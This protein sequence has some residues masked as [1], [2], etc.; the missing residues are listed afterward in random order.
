[1]FF[2]DFG[3]QYSAFEFYKWQ[4]CYFVLSA[5]LTLSSVWCRTR[6]TM[7]TLLTGSP[8]HP[9]Y[10]SYCREV[11]RLLVLLVAFHERNLL[12]Q[13]HYL[14]EWPK[15][16]TDLCHLKTELMSCGIWRN[17]SICLGLAFCIF[18]QHACRS[19]RC[20][21]PSWGQISCLAFQAAANCLCGEDIWNRPR[22]Y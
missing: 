6:M 18:C 16:A 4:V 20:C 13:H 21:A 2:Y 5:R 1:M 12:S 22:Q 9:A 8:I 11:S 14:A 3:S 17:K 15:Y 19:N 10:C 7:T